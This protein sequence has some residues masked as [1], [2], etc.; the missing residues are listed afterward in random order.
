MA[1]LRGKRRRK[2]PAVGTAIYVFA[3]DP[4][5]GPLVSIQEDIRYERCCKKGQKYLAYKWVANV[6][7]QEHRANIASVGV[8]LTLAL[9]DHGCQ[10]CEIWDPKVGCVRV[11]SKC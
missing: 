6:V 9:D 10:P 1:S 3:Y 7:L 4:K 11:Q 5:S 2:L 8:D